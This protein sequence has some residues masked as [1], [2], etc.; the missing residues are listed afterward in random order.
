MLSATTEVEVE[1]EV[2]QDHPN[3]PNHIID[4]MMDELGQEI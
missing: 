4:D 1:V 2:L 3:N